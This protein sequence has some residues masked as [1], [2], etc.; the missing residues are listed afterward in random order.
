MDF[1][2][3]LYDDANNI[4]QIQPSFYGQQYLEKESYLSPPFSHVKYKNM[5]AFQIKSLSGIW[6]LAG[7]FS[8]ESQQ[9][10]N[11]VYPQILTP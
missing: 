9:S 11:P 4:P 1:L 5:Y 6:V 10:D 3:A 2:P 8:R 7:C